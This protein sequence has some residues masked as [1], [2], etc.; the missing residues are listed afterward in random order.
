MPNTAYCK[1][2]E[3]R[4]GYRV[5]LEFPEKPGKEDTTGWEIKA[6]LIGALQEQ[7]EKTDVQR[8]GEEEV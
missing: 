7:L 4:E 8:W 3:I 2:E 1:K 5:V 6:M